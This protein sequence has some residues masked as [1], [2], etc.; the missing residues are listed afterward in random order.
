M[1][2]A[3]LEEAKRW[4]VHRWT[5][6]WNKPSSYT[7]G[8]PLHSSGRGVAPLLAQGRNSLAPPRP[9]SLFHIAIS[10]LQVWASA[11]G[12][13]A[14]LELRDLQLSFRYT[15]AAPGSPVGIPLR[16]E[17]HGDLVL[18]GAVGCHGS[19]GDH[20][21][22]WLAAGTN[23]TAEAGAALPACECECGWAGAWRRHCTPKLVQLR[24]C[25]HC[26]ARSL[27]FVTPLGHP[28]LRRQAPTAPSPAASAPVI[29]QRA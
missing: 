19:C 21:R 18:L 17:L 1:G 10:P 11:Q 29:R 16:V 8:L 7:W 25:L 23:A 20:G 28:S 5:P 22:C 26:G 9:P 14:R 27:F 12:G 6:L 15:L 4:G 2:T 13:L 24:A 3:V